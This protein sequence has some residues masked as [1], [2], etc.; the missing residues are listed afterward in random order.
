MA[1]DETKSIAIVEPTQDLEVT[2]FYNEALKLREYAETRIINSTEAM[3]LATDDLSVIARVK[4]S[5]EEKRKGFL[6]PFQNQIA[7]INDA[8]K[9]LAEPILQAD[10]LTRD[11]IL[12]YQSEQAR[13]AREQEEINRKRLEAAEAEMKLKGEITEPVN[14]VE[15]T[16]EAP[17]HISTDMGS[18]GQ[19]MIK[20]W[21]VVDISQVPDSYKIIDSAKVTKLVKGGGTIPGI[22]IWEEPIIAVRTK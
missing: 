9:T 10:K 13:I 22:R 19:R 3:K 2:S 16:P 8:F 1:E 5:I 6:A 15:V 12:A 7:F 4:K 17:K 18:I 14:L 11:K 21:E 20:K